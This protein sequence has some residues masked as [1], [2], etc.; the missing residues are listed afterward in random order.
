MQ[1]SG[2]GRWADSSNSCLSVLSVRSESV[3]TLRLRRDS[4]QPLGN[5]PMSM[6]TKHPFFHILGMHRFDVTT[7]IRILNFSVLPHPFLSSLHSATHCLAFLRKTLSL[8]FPLFIA[9]LYLVALCPPSRKHNF[10][11]SSFTSPISVSLSPGLTSRTL[12]FTHTRT[13]H[14]L[15]LTQAC[16]RDNFAHHSLQTRVNSH[17]RSCHHDIFF[18]RARSPVLTTSN[19]HPSKFSKWQFSKTSSLQPRCSL[20]LPWPFP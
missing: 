15:N 5:T 9:F 19:N 8:I 17:T 12:S 18:C 10:S 16:H 1:G 14:L 7:S 6:V 13:H 20:L 3:G 4:R 11:L 2:E